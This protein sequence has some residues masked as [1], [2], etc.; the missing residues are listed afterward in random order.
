M[1]DFARDITE[2]TKGQKEEVEVL[3]VV[4][5]NLF[6]KME[7]ARIAAEKNMDSKYLR[8]LR[9][10]P[11]DPQSLAKLTKVEKLFT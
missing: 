2:T 11:I 8:L 3:F 9:A 7:Y 6:S 4:M 1:T 10:Q 5:Q